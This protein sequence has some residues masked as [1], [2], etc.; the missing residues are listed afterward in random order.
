MKE[1]KMNKDLTVMN[2][3]EVKSLDDVTK[4]AAIFYKSNLFTDTKSE[5]QA[6]V[7]ILAGQELG[8]TPFVAM[9]SIDIIQGKT[10]MNGAAI[11]SRLKQSGYDFEVIENSKTACTLRFKQGLKTIKPDVSFTIEDAKDM[12]LAH[13]DNW[14]KQPAV[15]LFWRAVTK[16]ARMFCPHVFN[17]AIYTP[18]EL[19]SGEGVVDNIVITTAREVE[20]VDDEVRFIN[21]IPE[22]AEGDVPKELGV[23]AWLHVIEGDNAYKGKQL[24]DVPNAIIK[25]ILNPSFANKTTDRDRNFAALCLEMPERRNEI[26]PVMENEKAVP[27]E[28][29]DLPDFPEANDEIFIDENEEAEEVKNV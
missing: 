16:G 20:Q 17:G 23:N 6:V 8:L 4:L 2:K 15:M 27:I 11:S 19:R 24:R 1:N 29:D 10:C 9:N 25:K 7:K 18:E 28:L 13:K 14:K 3:L 22:E 21:H 12:N 5:A 26:D